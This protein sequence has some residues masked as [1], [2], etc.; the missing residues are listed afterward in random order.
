MSASK[1]SQSSSKLNETIAKY[2]ET[3][4][5]IS[6]LEKKVEKYREYIEYYMNKDNIDEIPY[7]SHLIKKYT[8]TRETISKKDVPKHIWDEYHKKSTSTCIRILN[9]KDKN[10]EKN[11]KKIYD[12]E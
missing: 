11:E 3:K 10:T 5:K 7:Q 12:S 2:I 4:E 9:K 8:L 6:E 1:S